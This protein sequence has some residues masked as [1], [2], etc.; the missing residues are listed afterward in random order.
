MFEISFHAFFR[1]NFSYKPHEFLLDHYLSTYTNFFLKVQ[2]H[3]TE[4]IIN[5]F[6]CQMPNM[7]FYLIFQITFLKKKY[8]ILFTMAD[9]RFSWVIRFSDKKIT[10]LDK[11]THISGHNFLHLQMPKSQQDPLPFTHYP[12]Q[13]T[14]H[15]PKLLM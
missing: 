4:F 13:L 5:F 1:A 8:K 11:I 3:L 6:F 10:I 9:L 2:D 12:G 15:G 7:T 14:R